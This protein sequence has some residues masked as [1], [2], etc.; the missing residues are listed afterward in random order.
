MAKP[1]CRVYWPAAVL[2]AFSASCIDATK[3]AAR[4]Q[5]KTLVSNR[6]FDGSRRQKLLS[7]KTQLR[8]NYE[9]GTSIKSL[10]KRQEI[11]GGTSR[12]PLLRGLFTAAKKFKEEEEPETFVGKMKKLFGIEQDQPPWKLITFILTWTVVVYIH[13]L[14]QS[15]SPGYLVVYFIINPIRWLIRVAYAYK[16]GLPVPDFF[17]GPDPDLFLDR[18]GIPKFGAYAPWTN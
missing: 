15:D 1:Y 16:M 11:S 18:P 14:L 3:A 10:W 5:S 13:M 12:R 4:V 9:P 17:E 2:L 7:V 6:Y 8:P